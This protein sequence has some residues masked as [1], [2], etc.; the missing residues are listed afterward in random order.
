MTHTR[1]HSQKA[2][3]HVD[4]PL[5]IEDYVT[6]SAEDEA[7]LADVQLH[8]YNLPKAL[9]AFPSLKSAARDR[10]HCIRP[11]RRGCKPSLGFSHTRHSNNLESKS[12]IA[13]K[14]PKPKGSSSLPRS[15]AAH[16]VQGAHGPV[17]HSTD[18]CEFCKSFAVSAF[19]CR[20]QIVQQFGVVGG[21]R[22]ESCH[23]WLP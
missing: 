20:K 10:K 14:Q 7:R 13:A 17:Q 16:G 19:V 12:R 22:L 15:P 2:S 23:R 3:C 8:L 4:L 6:Q 1:T 18:R 21:L 11:P 9:W 5:L